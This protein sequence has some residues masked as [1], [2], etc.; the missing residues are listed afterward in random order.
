MYEEALK[1]KR[2]PRC[3]SEL[4]EYL[5]EGAPGRKL[6]FLCRACC[7][8]VL[9]PKLRGEALADLLGDMQLL[10]A[11]AAKEVA[12]RGLE[13]ARGL[14][15]LPKLNVEKAEPGDERR[16]AYARAKRLAGEVR[17]LAE[18]GDAA[19]LVRK[20]GELLKLLDSLCAAVAACGLEPSGEF[21]DLEAVKEYAARVLMALA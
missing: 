12:R 6:V 7:E 20:L 15:E 1:T 19:E 3:G 17:G 4:L 16:E 18:S 11:A 8:L 10:G 2:C 9:P 21:E 13:P 5:A 14:P